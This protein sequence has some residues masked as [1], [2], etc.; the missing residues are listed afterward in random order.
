ME[1]C[2]PS[3]TPGQ[4]DMTPTVPTAPDPPSPAPLFHVLVS[5]PYYCVTINYPKTEQLKQ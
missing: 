5:L 2:P 3:P 1:P 4:A